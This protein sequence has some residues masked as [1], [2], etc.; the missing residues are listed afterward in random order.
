MLTHGAKLAATVAGSPLEGLLT[1]CF[2]GQ[3]WLGS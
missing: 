3:V 1:S 2:R